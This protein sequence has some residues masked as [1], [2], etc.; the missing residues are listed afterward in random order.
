MLR[1]P[2]ER[3]GRLDGEGPMA[4]TDE[5][6]AGRR[7]LVA[8]IKAILTRP[9]E[10][11]AVIDAEPATINGLYTG[12]VCIIAAIGPICMALGSI[13]FFHRVLGALISGIFSYGLWLAAVYGLALIVDYLAPRFG[14]Q[15]NRV[16]AFKVAAYSVTAS[17]LSGVFSLIPY[18]SFLAIV[19]FYSFYLL[20]L[21]APQL[22][23][24]APEKASDFG[25][26]CIAAV[27][28]CAFV[29]GLVISMALWPLMLMVGA[30]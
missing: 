8:R 10:E 3:I 14:G 5:G 7:A 28:V 22:M 26:V 23:K 21:G 15:S 18:L 16:Q 1:K 20:Y 19:G 4:V 13:I 11:W 25:L 9:K 12:Y 27:L 24:V 17:A 30:F 2:D 6:S 29:L